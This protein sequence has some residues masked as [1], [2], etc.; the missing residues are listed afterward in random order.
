MEC[1]SGF[2]LAQFSK[3]FAHV[4]DHPSELFVKNRN[5]RVRNQ[6]VPSGIIISSAVVATVEGSRGGVQKR[7]AGSAKRK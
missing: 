5:S 7:Q 3:H 1:S 6:V 4:S 2:A